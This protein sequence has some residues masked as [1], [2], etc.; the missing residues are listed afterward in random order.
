MPS[1]LPI[2]QHHNRIMHLVPLPTLR[3]AEHVEVEFFEALGDFGLIVEEAL[4]MDCFGAADGYAHAGEGGEEGH[5]RVGVA[6]RELG[7]VAR[8]RCYPVLYVFSQA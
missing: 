8:T 5:G 3:I 4:A 7:N 1:Y 2:L 6:S